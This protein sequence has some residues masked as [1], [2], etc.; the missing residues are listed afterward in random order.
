MF[1]FH[2]SLPICEVRKAEMI[3]TANQS[4]RFYSDLHIQ[5]QNK[6]R[7]TLITKFVR[8]NECDDTHDL[9]VLGTL[10]DSPSLPSAEELFTEDEM[11]EFEGFL[12]KAR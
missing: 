10:N 9:P 3:Q 2:F 7:Q 6:R 8:P 5:R 1:N 12:A 11:D 4:F